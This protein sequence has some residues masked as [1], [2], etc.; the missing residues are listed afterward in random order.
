M[1]DNII[2]VHYALILPRLQKKKKKKKLVKHVA[3]MHFT[4]CEMTIK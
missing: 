1:E 3:K 4:M 2:E